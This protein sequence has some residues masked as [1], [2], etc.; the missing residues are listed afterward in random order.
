MAIDTTVITDQDRNK[1]LES[2]SGRDK[3]GVAGEILT[4]TLAATG[5]AFSASAAAT[6]A[7]AST[8]FGSTT[9]GSALGCVFVA[10]TPLGWT[11]GCAVAAGFL[12]F[13]ISKLVRS[14]GKEDQKR[15]EILH[16]TR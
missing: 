7:G 8:I 5:G 1:A 6:A 16:T 10:S 15:K 13:G 14:G 4:T 2:L 12:G 11:V 3:I 9:L